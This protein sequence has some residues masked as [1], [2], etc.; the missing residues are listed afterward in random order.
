MNEL[1]IWF[2]FYVFGLIVGSFITYKFIKYSEKEVDDGKPA[3]Q[4][5]NNTTAKT[6]INTAL[7]F[8]IGDV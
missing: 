3:E 6:N 4:P 5:Y 8:A 2:M 1:I 7:S